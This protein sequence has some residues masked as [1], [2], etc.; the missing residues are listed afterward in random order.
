[1]GLFASQYV[2]THSVHTGCVPQ[3]V[4][5][6]DDNTAAI[7]HRDSA[8]YKFEANDLSY[9]DLPTKLRMRVQIVWELRR[10]LVQFSRFLGH[11]SWCEQGLKASQHDRCSRTKGGALV[12][13]YALQRKKL[14]YCFEDKSWSINE[15]PTLLSISLRKSFV[16]LHPF[17]LLRPTGLLSLGRDCKRCSSININN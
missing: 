4:A 10:S 16:T 9:T 5:G 2:A 11:V 7:R 3:D 1:M 6:I 14:R 13:M 15:S 17:G 8:R 12:V